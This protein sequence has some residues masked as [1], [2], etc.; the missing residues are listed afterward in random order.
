MNDANHIL[1]MDFIN[2]KG[3]NMYFFMVN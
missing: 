2:K 3:N 1:M